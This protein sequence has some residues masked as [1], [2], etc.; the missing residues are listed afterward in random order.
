MSMSITVR[1]ALTSQISLDGGKV[2]LNVPASG[3]LSIPVGKFVGNE[4]LCSQLSNLVTHGSI[5]V[6]RGATTI[7]AADLLI[8]GQG[9][10]MPQGIYDKDFNEI[11]DAAESL[12]T[13]ATSVTVSNHLVPYVVSSSNDVIFLNSTTG[14]LFITL[15]AAATMAGKILT[16]KDISGTA[17]GNAITITPNLLETIDGVNAPIILNTAYVDLVLSC[18]GVG[19]FA[20]NRMVQLRANWETNLQAVAATADVISFIAPGPGRVTAVRAVAGTTA[21]A[22]EDMEV[23]LLIDGVTCLTG[24]IVLDDTAGIL[25]QTGTLDPAAVAIAAGDVVTISRVYTA[26]GAP[27]P[28]ANTTVSF[29]FE[30]F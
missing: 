9:A 23:D 19:W 6:L 15:P 18:N 5:T 30:L 22:A 3:T 27:T 11:A 2:R 21:A 4:Q 17:A 8:Y 14:A 24:P 29:F 28:M 12:D 1:N 13:S 25:V 26:G 16:F 20:M 7:S 10:D